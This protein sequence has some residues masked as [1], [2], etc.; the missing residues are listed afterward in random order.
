MNIAVVSITIFNKKC[1]FLKRN[2]EPKNWC[3]PCGRLEEDEEPIDGVKRE[4][5]EETN[6]K[7][8]PLMPV[9]AKVV[10]YNNKNLYSITYVS[11]ASS[12]KVKLSKEHSDYKWVDIEDLKD[13]DINTDFKIVNWPL[14]I[15]TA[16]LY[17]KQK[18]TI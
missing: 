10:L 1:L 14:F 18:K 2:F 15:E 16:F 5:L 13:V 4:V 3:P 7:I 17:A 9:D 6:L 12:N 8:I 11:I